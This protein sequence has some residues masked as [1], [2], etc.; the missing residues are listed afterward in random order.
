[1][2][3]DLPLWTP[4]RERAAGSNLAKF[5]LAA[6]ERSGRA[7]A[8]FDEL[9]RWSTGDSEAFWTLMWEF[10]GVKGTRG[11]RTLAD[12]AKMPGARWFPGC[13]PQLRGEPAAPP[14]D[15]R[16]AGFLG[17][18]PHQAAAFVGLTC[19]AWFRVSPKRFGPKA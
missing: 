6:G 12:G 1:M 11:A 17:R 16:R 7:F 14:R 8:S 15:V 4:S 5:M 2:D 3:E 19:T 13:A 18:G 9:H 10:G